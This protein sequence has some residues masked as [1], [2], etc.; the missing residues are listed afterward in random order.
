MHLGQSRGVARA[1]GDDDGLGE[2]FH[3][4]MRLRRTDRAVKG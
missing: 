1:G 2:T 3:D 4:P